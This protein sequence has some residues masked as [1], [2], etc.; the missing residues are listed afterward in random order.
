MLTQLPDWSKDN[1][2]G[3]DAP[4]AIGT[5][6]EITLNGWEGIVGVVQGYKDHGW[7]MVC[8]RPY[9]RPAWHLAEHPDRHVCLFAGCELKR[10]Y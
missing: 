10:V 7:I 8:V 9:K 4:P 6:V 3:K 2:S 1:W 5:E